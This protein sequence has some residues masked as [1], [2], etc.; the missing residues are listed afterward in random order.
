MFLEQP[1]D[2]VGLDNFKSIF[3]PAGIDLK[4]LAVTTNIGRTL[5]DLV[6]HVKLNS[7]YKLEYEVLDKKMVQLLNN[8]DTGDIRGFHKDNFMK[9][10]P[11]GTI[12]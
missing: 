8:M 6:A 5:K 10:K 3:A 11:F 7:H 4:E 2:F 1:N 12:L 9:F